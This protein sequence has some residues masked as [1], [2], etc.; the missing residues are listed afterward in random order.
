MV[1]MTSFI[2]QFFVHIKYDEEMTRCLKINPSVSRMM[3]EGNCIF[4]F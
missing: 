2:A 4:N 3:D 1:T